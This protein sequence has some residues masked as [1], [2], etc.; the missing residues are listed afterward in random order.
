MQQSLT[1]VKDCAFSRLTMLY[2]FVADTPKHLGS[3]QVLSHKECS[4]EH[5]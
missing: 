2:D 5:K 1:K 4:V 3:V